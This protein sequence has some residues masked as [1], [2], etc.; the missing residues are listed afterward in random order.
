MKIFFMIL[1]LGANAFAS[2]SQIFEC[3]M[4]DLTVNDS[5]TGGI[6]KLEVSA[7][8]TL[9]RYGEEVRTLSRINHSESTATYLE[10]NERGRITLSFDLLPSGESGV[11]IWTNYDRKEPEKKVVANRA[12]YICH[13]QSG[14][15]L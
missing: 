7:N 3:D 2:P 10:R 15:Q 5:T 6:I 14:E 11:F 4:R 12:V 8:E 9:K 13:K 1:L